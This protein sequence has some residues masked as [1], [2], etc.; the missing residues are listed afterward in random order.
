LEL[1]ATNRSDDD[2]PLLN[3]TPPWA[4]STVVANL[5]DLFRRGIPKH[6]V[7][8]LHLDAL[9]DEQGLGRIAAWLGARGAN[10]SRMEL[11]FPKEA[12]RASESDTDKSLNQAFWNQLCGLSSPLMQNL[13][14]ARKRS[15]DGLADLIR[16]SGETVPQSLLAPRPVRA[17]SCERARLAA[18]DR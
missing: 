6:R 18:A 11:P 14:V 12:S 5:H 7:K 10:R 8:V 16:S 15:T 2:E 3:C 13:E 17:I 4:E 9:R 1:I